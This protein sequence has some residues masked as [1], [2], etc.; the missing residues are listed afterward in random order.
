MVDRVTYRGPEARVAQVPEVR[1]S[2]GA[3]KGFA[4]LASTFATFADQAQEQRDRI[5]VTEAKRAGMVAGATGTPKLREDKWTLTGSAYN[6][7]ALQTYANTI[8]AKARTKFAQFAAENAAD[9]TSYQRSAAP[10]ASGIVD[11]VRSVAP[12]LAP[13]FEQKFQSIMVSDV[14]QIRT[15]Q[16]AVLR[17]EQKAR[18]HTLEDVIHRNID[19]T[20][21]RLFS[22]DPTV[23]TSWLVQASG[24][25]NR[26][27]M[28]YDQIGPDGQ[29]LMTREAKAKARTAYWDRVYASG[30]K[31]WV[32]QQT[33]KTAAFRAIS[34]GDVTI[35]ARTVDEQGN[36]TEEFMAFN[37]SAE[38]TRGERDK[39]I[40]YARNQ[41]NA[42]I[43]AM[44]RQ[45]RLEREH[46]QEV[47]EATSKAMYDAMAPGGG[48]LTVD[49]VQAQRENLTGTDY[50]TLLMAATGGEALAD[51]GDAIIAIEDAMRERGDF[52]LMA[53]QM[54]TDR[55]I[56]QDTLRYY[57]SQNDLLRTKGGMR[58]EYQI[59]SGTF[60]DMLQS[61]SSMTATKYDDLRLGLPVA[62]SEFHRWWTQFPQ[63]TDPRTGEPFGRY[64]T[65]EEGKAKT[66]T[67]L[68]STLSGAQ[69]SIFERG[70]LGDGV[71]VPT[72]NIRVGGT[73]H[74]FAARNNE[75]G[76]ID[77]EATAINLYRAFGVDATT[78]EDQRPEELDRRLEE[79]Y[80]YR[81]AVFAMQEVMRRIDNGR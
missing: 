19:A 22:D 72:R 48:G 69:R 20:A 81:A 35:K 17:D 11:E 25:W 34:T 29:P 54:Y 23:A 78:P 9:P 10:Y 31:A 80:Q 18:I 50:R 70:F 38:M 6:D 67:L 24:D 5:A 75:S 12:W 39:I 15:K 68:Q 43:R 28:M 32:D 60:D 1:I 45:D 41:M 27:S 42:E 63:Q 57:R 66:F 30:L 33:D 55:R 73:S 14:T 56:T 51:D 4:D 74:P 8:E 49:A 37:P 61:L 77:F 36:M 71:K 76:E 16:T 2:F 65:F 21:G 7:A 44:N 13:L 59:L 47:E 40:A 64:P 62:K 3:A 52:W 53:R 46:Q 79:L 26:V 58:T